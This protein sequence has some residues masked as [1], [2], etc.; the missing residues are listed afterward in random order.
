[1]RDLQVLLDE[2]I[3]DLSITPSDDLIDLI[4]LMERTYIHALIEAHLR[5]VSI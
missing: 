3:A 4:H 2:K 5:G 1:M